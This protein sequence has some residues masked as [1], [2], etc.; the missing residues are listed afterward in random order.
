MKKKT[1]WKE[2]KDIVD[3]RTLRWQRQEYCSVRARLCSEEQKERNMLIAVF[4]VSQKQENWDQQGVSPFCLR[5]SSPAWF[6]R[7]ERCSRT[8]NQSARGPSWSSDWPGNTHPQK[9]VHNVLSS[10]FASSSCLLIFLYVA[11]LVVAHQ[12]H[13]VGRFLTCLSTR[14][15]GIIY[16]SDSIFMHWTVSV[17]S[18][19]KSFT[20]VSNNVKTVKV[21]IK[22]SFRHCS[23]V[24]FS[25]VKNNPENV[26]KHYFSLATSIP[27]YLDQRCI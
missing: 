25:F 22:N 18:Q 17:M 26:A 6:R 15:T 19:L 13:I 1:K 2:N 4:L 9:R 3:E 16:H 27:T 10:I 23:I 7:G 21:K 8:T 12:V 20:K 24:P 14:I 5:W 11:S